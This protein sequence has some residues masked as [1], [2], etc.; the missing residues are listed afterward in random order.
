[1]GKK[2]HDPLLITGEFAEA[3]F[4]KVRKTLNAAPLGPLNLSL[5]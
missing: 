1:M 4:V 3:L 5:E 2:F